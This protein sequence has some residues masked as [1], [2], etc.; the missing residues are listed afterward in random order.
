LCWVTGVGS[1]LG[2]HFTRDRPVNAR[3]AYTDRINEDLYHLTHLYMRTR[4][5]LYMTEHMP[6]L[7]PSM[8]HTRE[9]ANTL[10]EEFKGL[11]SEIVHK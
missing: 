2:I 7:L 8:I 6:H 5:I 4:G 3:V 9:H 11:L 10:V 1:M